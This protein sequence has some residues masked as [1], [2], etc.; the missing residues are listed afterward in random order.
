LQT[1]KGSLKKQV[2]VENLGVNKYNIFTQK[3][4]ESQ[5]NNIIALIFILLLNMVIT[6]TYFFYFKEFRG[7]PTAN[8]F[9]DVP[10]KIKNTQ[11]NHQILV[12][13]DSDQVWDSP[14]FSTTEFNKDLKI[15]NDGNNSWIKFWIEK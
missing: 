11:D 7:Y 15:I 9:S 4:A 14:L 1:I 13:I 6:K 2:G 10:L 5:I 12:P 8:K 3:G